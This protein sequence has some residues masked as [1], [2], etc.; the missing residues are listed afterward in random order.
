[1]IKMT[2]G[3]FLCLEDTDTYKRVFS[4][5]TKSREGHCRVTVSQWPRVRNMYLM[6]TIC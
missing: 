5:I 2:I 6:N 4:V 1:M 3:G